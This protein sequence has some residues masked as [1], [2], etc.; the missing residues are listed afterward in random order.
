MS[1]FTKLTKKQT[2][3]KPTTNLARAITKGMRRAYSNYMEGQKQTSKN[4]SDDDKLYIYT[5]DPITWKGINKKSRNLFNKW[6]EVDSPIDG[7]DIP[8]PIE[9]RVQEFNQNSSL[10]RKM[11]QNCVNMLVQGNGYLELQCLEPEDIGLETELSPQAE[12]IDI[13]VIDPRTIKQDRVKN[14]QAD[15]IN[16]I[17]TPLPDVEYFVQRQGRGKPNLLVHPSR[18]IHTSI[19]NFGDSSYGISPIE[20]AFKVANSKINSD[21]ALGEILFR[22]GKPFLVCNIE[23]GTDEDIEEVFSALGKLNPKTGFA[24]TNKYKFQILNPSGVI[25]PKEFVDAFYTN[26][27]CALEMPLMI[28]LGVQKGAVTGSEVDLS[29]YYNDLA[30]IQE[31][32]MTPVL[33]RIYTQLFGVWDYEV[34]WNIIFVDEKTK[35]EQTKIY[36]EVIKILYS[37]SGIIDDITARQMCREW[38]IPIPEEHELDIVEEPIGNI[39]IV[40][41]EPPFEEA[42]I[43]KPTQEELEFAERMRSLG[44]KELVEQEKRLK[45]NHKSRK[46]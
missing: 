41:I 3:N 37:D 22:F 13:A 15:K 32:V 28:L 42:K 11:M 16:N 34:F 43:R 10:K 33:N 24:G 21:W 44:E 1:F 30:S 25:H 31:T 8:E 36:A 6:F 2:N 23:D 12:L 7:E 38:D 17:Q 45:Q 46:K 39:P 26:L 9:T 40:E 5:H 35:A 4:L 19:Y 14:E 29:D 18:I 27:A 20:V